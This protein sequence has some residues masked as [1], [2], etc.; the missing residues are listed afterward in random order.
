M[1][2]R[3]SFFQD[4][5][6]DT[7][8]VGQHVF[9]IFGLS[10]YIYILLLFFRPLETCAFSEQNPCSPDFQNALI[11]LD[12]QKNPALLLKIKQSA[13][14]GN[15]VGLSCLGELY[16]NGWGV[17]G[18]EETAWELFQQAAQKGNA[19]AMHRIGTMYEL[20]TYVRK[21]YHWALLWYLRSAIRGYTD[22]QTDAGILYE[23]GLGGYKD[24]VAALFWYKKAAAQGDPFAIEAVQRL[25]PQK[26][27]D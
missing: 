22:A 27:E 12:H 24:A 20:G 15:G 25:Q 16:L 3:H 1:L 26:I 17:K 18:D 21:D 7:L 19:A 8:N 2:I 11:Q 23:D 10:L 13:A 4:S 14:T 5:Y 9:I 6:G